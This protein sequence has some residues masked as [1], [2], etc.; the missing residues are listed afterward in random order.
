MHNHAHHKRQFSK[1]K[2][3]Q[4]FKVRTEG[5]KA[6]GIKSVGEM[7]GAGAGAK[8]VFWVPVVA[9]ACLKPNKNLL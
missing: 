3:E 1:T 8:D 9:G 7:Q 4:A 2:K 5:M 6:E